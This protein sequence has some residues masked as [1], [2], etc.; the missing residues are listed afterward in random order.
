MTALATIIA[1]V[2]VLLISSCE[3][4]LRFAL[5]ADS[6][7]SHSGDE[8]SDD[9]RAQ[10][11]RG[12]TFLLDA[13]DV[14]IKSSDGLALHAYLKENKGH[15]TLI[16]IHGY[17]GTAFDN[18]SLCSYFYEKGYSVLVPDLRCHGKSEGK[19]ISMGKRESEDIL[20][21]IEYIS[22]MDKSALVALHGVSMGAA[23][24][25]LASEKRLE[26]VVAAIEDCGYSDLYD[27][28][29]IQLKA[30]FGLAAHPLLDFVSLWTKIRLGFTFK[31]ISP[32][33]CL[34]NTQIPMLFIHGESDDFVP[35]KMVYDC[36][37]S[38]KGEKEL[39][40]TESA[41]HA[42]SMTKYSDKYNER[43]YEFIERYMTN[44]T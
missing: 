29:A 33:K 42:E 6:S 34:E 23:T 12:K 4:F 31:S 3:F 25:M 2:L 37:E 39:W 20:C 10:R 15:K 38:H 9:L 7:L 19:Y 8:I 32:G 35:A 30:M 22:E 36:Y 24:L 26:N 40:V 43:S 21:W 16:S 41:G 13:R 28:F 27:E 11:E 5:K 44:H 14:Y 17:K 1:I 18:S